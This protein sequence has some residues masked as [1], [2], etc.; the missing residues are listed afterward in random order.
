VR[1]DALEKVAFVSAITGHDPSARAA[2]ELVQARL[3]HATIVR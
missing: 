1:L 2:D 3:D